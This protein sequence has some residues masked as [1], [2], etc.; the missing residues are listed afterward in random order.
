MKTAI[1]TAAVMTATATLTGC[2]DEA[3]DVDGPGVMTQS[4]YEYFA[5]LEDKGSFPLEDGRCADV[6][7]TTF[8][9]G[10]HE[11]ANTLYL[12]YPNGCMGGLTTIDLTRING[13][14][15]GTAGYYYGK[16]LTAEG[17]S[18]VLG[19][20]QMDEELR[21]MWSHIVVSNWT[22]EVDLF[23]EGMV[24]QPEE[25]GPEVERFLGYIGFDKLYSE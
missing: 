19:E 13:N 1:L 5:S 12:Q 16:V 24:L 20:W 14:E 22:A 8:R 6:V 3:P 23:I 10:R 9:G 7:D 18:V 25:D 4:D 2:A 17:D 21:V 15:E 11:A